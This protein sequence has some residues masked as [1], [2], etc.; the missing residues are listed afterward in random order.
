MESTTCHDADA[1]AVKPWQRLRDASRHG[2]KMRFV[3]YRTL[4]VTARA[5]LKCQAAV[6]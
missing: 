4:A 1:D 5:E 2:T 6:T 3:P